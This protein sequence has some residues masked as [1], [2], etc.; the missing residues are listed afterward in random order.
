L[1]P[2][3][4][5]LSNTLA[6][7]KPSHLV[8]NPYPFHTL[9]SHGRRDHEEDRGERATLGSFRGHEPAPH[10]LDPSRL[11]VE[12]ATAPSFRGEGDG[13]LVVLDVPEN[14]P[15]EFFVGQC[16]RVE[17]A[18]AVFEVYRSG[19]PASPA[20]ARTGEIYREEKSRVSFRIEAGTLPFAPGDT[21]SF[22]TFE[23]VSRIDELLD[24][25]GS[26]RGDLQCA[27]RSP[28]PIR[29]RPC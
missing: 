3:K 26:Q 29:K 8:R 5:A 11:Q 10:R 23:D 7:S 12:T 24:P 21:F 2:P 28:L 25:T 4:A 18:G 14:V 6:A 13:K 27:P 15:L 1:R 17:E 16:A 20:N 19:E 22:V 9:L